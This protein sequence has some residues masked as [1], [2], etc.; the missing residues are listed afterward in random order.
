MFLNNDKKSV[1]AQNTIKATSEIRLVI[2]GSVGSGKTTSIKTVSQL[3]MIS[4]EAK[5]TEQEVLHRKA[6]TTVGVE[7][8]ALFIRKTKLH[9][10]GTPGQKRFDFI[11]PVLCK[12]AAG[13][14]VMI[15][16]GCNDPLR[17]L[18]YF[19]NFHGPYLKKNPGIIAV[20]HYDDI[21]TKTSLIDYHCHVR[22]HGLDC[23]VMRLDARKEDQ[24]KKVILKL[25]FEISHRGCH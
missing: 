13:M 3:P 6:T 12:G 25:L 1:T 17:E 24:V 19:L 5:A 21:N 9:I 22:E 4:C 14:I 23:A 16:N 7:Y 18:N 15:D 20:T 10:Y 8:G 2:V 11:A